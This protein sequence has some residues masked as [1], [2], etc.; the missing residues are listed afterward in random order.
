QRPLPARSRPALLRRRD[1]AEPAAAARR[2]RDGAGPARA[3]DLRAGRGRRPAVLRAPARAHHARRGGGRCR[4]T[5]PAVGQRRPALRAAPGRRRRARDLPPRCALAGSSAARRSLR[6]APA[7]HRLRRPDPARA[8]RSCGRPASA[9]AHRCQDDDGHRPMR[10]IETP[11]EE[12]AVAGETDTDAYPRRVE[13]SPGVRSPSA[14][15]DSPGSRPRAT[16]R[17]TSRSS[18]HSALEDDDTISIGALLEHLADHRW[19]FAG[20]TALCALAALAYALL[21]TPVYTGDALVQVEDK[22]GSALG[23]L[24][25]VAQAL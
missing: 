20:V 13:G 11:G 16:P 24:S 25:S 21:A 5:E 3:Q 18:S 23:A 14:F 1:V 7:R 2:H 15:L 6:A 10:H 17:S 12:P 19:L 9:L 8:R 22:K 4:R